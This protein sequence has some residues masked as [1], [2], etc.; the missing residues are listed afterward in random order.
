MAFPIIPLRLLILPSLCLNCADQ[1]IDMLLFT[2]TQVIKSPIQGKMK[3]P[4]TVYRAKKG[5]LEGEGRKDV[6]IYH[7]SNSKAN[8]VLHP[9]SW[10]P[11]QPSKS[12]LLCSI[13]L[14][15]F[16]KVNLFS[17][18][19]HLSFSVNS[20]WPLVHVQPVAILSFY[21]LWG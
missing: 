7:D 21:H 13:S 1:N 5:W 19:A 3:N 18:S 16:S 4:F 10:P 2:E 12:A 14:K 9:G 15:L 20:F 6:M 11:T 17:C 8:L